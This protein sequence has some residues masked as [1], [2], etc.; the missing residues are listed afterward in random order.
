MIVGSELRFDLV[1]YKVYH[2]RLVSEVDKREYFKFRF[3]VRRIEDSTSMRFQY[4]LVLA[5][6]KMSTFN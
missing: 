5:S 6:N 4:I 1:F 2:A 3:D